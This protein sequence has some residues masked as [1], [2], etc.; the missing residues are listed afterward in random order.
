MSGQKDRLVGSG[1]GSSDTQVEMQEQPALLKY[2][3]RC[4]FNA[5]LPFQIY[6][7]AG[8]RF[9]KMSRSYL[10]Y[11][12]QVGR[13]QAS[14]YLDLV[15][16]ATLWSPNLYFLHIASTQ[17]IFFLLQD[18]CPAISR[19]SFHHTILSGGL[20]ILQSDLRSSLQPS[21]TVCLLPF[22]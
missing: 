4:N 21:T 5:S 11:S 12:R 1:V 19:L 15:F 6:L 9:P 14:S 2:I 16:T 18:Y 22:H 3:S 20:Q 10:D 8:W 17:L 13:A 7:Y